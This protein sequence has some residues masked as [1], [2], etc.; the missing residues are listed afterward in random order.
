[1]DDGAVVYSKLDTG[2]PPTPSLVVTDILAHLRTAPAHIPP[3]VSSPLHPPPSHS[4]LLLLAP[5]ILLVAV[6]AAVLLRRRPHPP[7]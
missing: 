7:S 2:A 3:P 6:T 5:A 1:M 4:T